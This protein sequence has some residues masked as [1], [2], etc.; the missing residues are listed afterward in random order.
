MLYAGKLVQL[1]IDYYPL[2]IREVI[3]MYK[4]QSFLVSEETKVYLS[5][6]VYIYFFWLGKILVI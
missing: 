6:L 3:I 5:T 1:E 4:E 2:M